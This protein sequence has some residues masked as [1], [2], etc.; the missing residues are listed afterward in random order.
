LPSSEETTIKTYKGY[1]LFDDVE[2]FS[3]KVKNRGVVMANIVDE[4]CHRS[5]GRVTPTGLALILGYFRE[6]PVHERKATKIAFEQVLTE[7]GIK[8]ES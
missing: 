7:R 5:N 1:S 3:L 6:V 8:Y 2:D 4:H